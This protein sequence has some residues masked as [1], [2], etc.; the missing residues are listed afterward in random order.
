M[1][2]MLVRFD[3]ARDPLANLARED[4]LFQQVERRELPEQVRFW[5]VSECLVRGKARS[6]KYGWYRESVAKTMGIEVMVRTTGGGV[7]Y[8]DEGNLNWSFFLR[9]TGGLVSPTRVFEWA[10]VHIVRALAE[11]G[12]DA[13]FVPPHRIDAHDRKVS[14][15]AA[16]MTPRTI[17]VHGTLLLD[18]DLEKLN[19]LCIP[20]AG[21]P[22][23]VNLREWLPGIEASQV[24]KAVAGALKNADFDVK[25]AGAEMD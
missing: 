21:C 6:A 7:V 11:L 24:V 9:N 22:P 13:R 25:M 10:S 1:R 3:R 18:S 15:M 5:K 8:H 16:R 17:L 2:E 19:Q 14:G 20:P 4:E 23:V 12:V